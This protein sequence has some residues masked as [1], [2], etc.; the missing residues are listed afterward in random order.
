MQRQV[1]QTRFT[2]E[3]PARN[4]RNS[5][6]GRFSAED[7]FF[8][9]QVRESSGWRTALADRTGSRYFSARRRGGKMAREDPASQVAHRKAGRKARRKDLLIRKFRSRLSP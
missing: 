3:G 2:G 9:Y 7:P 4:E 8:H 5:L 1:W 6:P